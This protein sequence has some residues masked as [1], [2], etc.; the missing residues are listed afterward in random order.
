MQLGLED[1]S[2]APRSSGTSC[3]VAAVRG[4]QCAR[5][6]LK[7]GETYTYE[8]SG[9]WSCSPDGPDLTCDGDETGSGRLVGCLYQEFTL[10]EEFDLG[11]TG[12]FTAPA[13]GTLYLAA[14]THGGAWP[15]IRGATFKCVRGCNRRTVERGS[16]SMRTSLSQAIEPYATGGWQRRVVGRCVDRRGGSAARERSCGAIRS[17]GGRL[18]RQRQSTGSRGTTTSITQRL[19]L[20]VLNL[21]LLPLRPAGVHTHVELAAARLL[22]Q[23][24]DQLRKLRRVD[25]EVP[26]FN[27]QVEVRFRPADVDL[28]RHH[29]LGELVGLVVAVGGTGDEFPWRAHSSWPSTQPRFVSTRITLRTG[30]PVLD[31]VCATS[32]IWPRWFAGRSS[33]WAI[34]RHDT[35]HLHDPVRLEGDAEVLQGQPHVLVLGGE[36]RRR[37]HPFLPDPELLIIGTD[38]QLISAA[39]GVRDAEAEAVPRSTITTPLAFISGPRSKRACL[40]DQLVRPGWPSTPVIFRLTRATTWSLVA[41]LETAGMTSAGRSLSDWQA[42]AVSSAARRCRS[43]RSAWWSFRGCLAA[44]PSSEVGPVLSRGSS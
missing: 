1:E 24:P 28:P 11:V 8:A 12:S 22:R 36:D 34:D 29:H 33:Y 16:Q 10:T 37:V 31:F 2:A 4:W 44:G 9:D 3:K 5:V 30:S 32:S 19:V 13:E 15:T 27:P 26:E 40:Q 39:D 20:D 23:G 17:L 14:G 21:R 6:K 18:F 43:R 42:V 41:V 35:E 38:V 7:A 25:F